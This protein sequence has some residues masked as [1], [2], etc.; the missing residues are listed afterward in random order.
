MA[1]DSD[2]PNRIFELDDLP[3]SPGTYFN[4]KTEVLVIVDDSAT[5][6]QDVFASGP[7]RRAAWVKV[8]DE[9]PVDESARDE[10]LE[11][12]ETDFH[13]G[14]TGAPPTDDEDLEEDLDE[15]HDKGDLDGAEDDLEDEG[16][17]DLD[18]LEKE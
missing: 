7:Y 12:F 11:K 3:D 2:A 16:E 15:D 18:D 13:P 10:A 9:V 6:D 14:A 4:P 5:I 8:G 1:S 17:L